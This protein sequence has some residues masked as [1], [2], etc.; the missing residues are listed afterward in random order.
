MVIYLLRTNSVPTACAACFQEFIWSNIS[1]LAHFP[2][3]A[4]FRLFVS[5]NGRDDSDNFT[6]RF[7]F[8][9]ITY[10]CYGLEMW[11]VVITTSNFCFCRALSF[12]FVSDIN[13]GTALLYLTLTWWQVTH[14]CYQRQII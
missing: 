8:S 4:D 3:T 2:K 9:S 13:F 5:Q 10:N 6:Q 11:M 12:G 7:N 1:A 14:L